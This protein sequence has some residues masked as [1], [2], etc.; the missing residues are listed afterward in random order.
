MAEP[1]Q[2]GSSSPS[3]NRTDAGRLPAARPRDLRSLEEEKAFLR[4]LEGRPGF[5]RKW[6]GYWSLSGPGW[7][8]S[9]VTLGAGSAG[10]SIYAGAVFGYSLLWVQ[11]VAMFL[12]VVVFAAIGHQLLVTQ[13]RPYQ[14]FRQRLHPA[15][16][17]FW[18]GNVLLAS[19]IWQFPQYAL[20]TAVLKDILAVAG[21]NAPRAPLAG[22]LLA[23]VT[24]FCWSTGSRSRRAT[25]AFERALKYLLLAMA[26]AFFL[27]VIRTGV[28]W[29]GLARG[30]L[31]FHVP[32]TRE[33]LTIVLGML[34]AAVGVN[35]TFLYP[36]A[37]LARG[38]GREHR[39]LKNFDLVT[40]MFL[41]F[42]LA[43]SFVV[44]ACANTLHVRGIRVSGPLDAARAL[45][46][47]I[48][49]TAARIVFS[50]GVLSM[51]FTTAVIEMLVCG[52]V[53]GEIFGFEARGRAYRAGTMLANVG[54]IGAFTSLPLWLPVMA[55]S[56]NLVMMPIAYAGFLILQNKKSYLGTDVSRGLKGAVWNALLLL[57]LLIV[58]AG[59]V[60]R[61]LSLFGG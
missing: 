32:R 16:A 15:I 54:V 1:A 30:L 27:V 36:Y 26:A 43:T 48:G 13:E 18:G 25:R 14:V 9:A 40:S 5:Y 50:L 51:C 24:V 47:L 53:L 8:Q 46:P 12:G 3:E 42:V 52:F 2:S 20:G 45:E 41:P 44:I 29:A 38:W 49:L 19:I 39:G 33:G 21:V 60:V 22:L 17:L 31:G 10:S 58:T 57:A 37:L 6:R 35:M 34:G 56:L 55:S 4:D 11:P 61:L 59:A 28:D 7:L 23:S